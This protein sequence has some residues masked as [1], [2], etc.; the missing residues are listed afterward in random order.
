VTIMGCVLMVLF[1][2]F[3]VLLTVGNTG[4]GEG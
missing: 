3:F 1:G 4:S 2:A